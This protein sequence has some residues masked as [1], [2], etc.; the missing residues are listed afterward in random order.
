MSL[1][2]RTDGGYVALLPRSQGAASSVLAL[3]RDA[4]W[5]DISTSELDLELTVVDPAS[6]HLFAVRIRV[7]FSAEGAA[8]ASADV[9]AA[10]YGK[11]WLTQHGL[12]GIDPWL[13]DLFLVLFRCVSLGPSVLHACQCLLILNM[14]DALA[15]ARGC[16]ER[17]RAWRT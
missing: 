17:S 1:H 8:S 16:G 11:A 4:N 3:L 6:K 13:S 7:V 5:L 10:S 14:L 12:P 2:I 9:L 15:N